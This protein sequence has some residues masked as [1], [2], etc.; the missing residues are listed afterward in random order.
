M[1]ELFLVYSSQS[2][3]KNTSRV[4]YAKRIARVLRQPSIQEE[5]S[6]A[7]KEEAS[8][9]HKED[10]NSEHRRLLLLSTR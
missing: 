9:D 5:P 2:F 4:G 10:S 7:Q 3:I 8:D 6:E 1:I